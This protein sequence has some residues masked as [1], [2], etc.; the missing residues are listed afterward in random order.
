MGFVGGGD[1]VRDHTPLPGDPQTPQ[2]FITESKSPGI[3][4]Q[5]SYSV[6]FFSYHS[7]MALKWVR[8]MSHVVNELL[9]EEL[10]LFLSLEEVTLDKLSSAKQ[11]KNLGLVKSVS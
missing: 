11:E 2:F 9:P 4:S 10:A 7:S 6:L 8:G 3:P 1:T 5:T